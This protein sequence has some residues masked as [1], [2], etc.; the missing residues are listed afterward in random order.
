MTADPD[1][2][3]IRR[4]LAEASAWCSSRASPDEPAASLRS[5]A[6]RAPSIYATPA[7]VA[8]WGQYRRQD[9]SSRTWHIQWDEKKEAARPI[10]DAERTA[11]VESLASRRS[12]LLG[13]NASAPESLIRGQAGG[14]VLAY[15]PDDND[16]SGAS[17]GVTNGYFSFHDEPP[18]DTWLVYI[19]EAVMGSRISY[20]LSWVPDIFVATVE[21]GIDV[22]ATRSLV[23]ATDFESEYIDRLRNAGLMM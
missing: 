2:G 18:W 16:A 12:D 22:N 17:D 7:H 13:L 5:D 20:L 9:F 11:I 3:D 6:L 8:L 1:F 21:R 10:I 15:F 23:W 19:D 14:R 4:R